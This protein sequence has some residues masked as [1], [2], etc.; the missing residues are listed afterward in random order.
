M[1]AMTKLVSVE[2]RDKDGSKGEARRWN[3]QGLW[4]MGVEMNKRVKSR[5][6]KEAHSLQMAQFPNGCHCYDISYTS[7]WI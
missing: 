5:M 3:C 4:I 7:V 2:R 1:R 6:E